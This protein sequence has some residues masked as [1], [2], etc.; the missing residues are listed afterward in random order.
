M[1]K[2]PSQPVS[3][4]RRGSNRA[5]LVLLRELESHS[6]RHGQ[7]THG[8]HVSAETAQHTIMVE[9]TTLRM[10]TADRCTCG[11]CSCTALLEDALHTYL[12]TTTARDAR[13]GSNNSHTQTHTRRVVLT[14][15]TVQPA[16]AYMHSKTF[17]QVHALERHMTFGPSTAQ[18]QHSTAAPHARPRHGLGQRY[19]HWN[20]LNAFHTQKCTLNCSRALSAFKIGLPE[21]LPH[22]NAVCCR[23]AGVLRQ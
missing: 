5:G 16:A 12:C 10:Q 13:H 21:R 23:L 3:W 11:V 22:Q 17:L 6:G 18:Q 1:H 8:V 2:T 20:T 9:F 4:P 15:A 14:T 7:R 19:C